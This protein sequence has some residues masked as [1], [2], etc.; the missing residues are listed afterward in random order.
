[1][2]REN[3][4]RVMANTFLC[5]GSFHKAVSPANADRVDSSPRWR[6]IPLTFGVDEFEQADI[7]QQRAAN[8]FMNLP[9]DYRQLSAEWQA[10]A[11][12]LRFA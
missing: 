1:M 11:C 6:P 10:P 7:L 3:L 9:L 4:S 12:G 8:C 2:P 5:D